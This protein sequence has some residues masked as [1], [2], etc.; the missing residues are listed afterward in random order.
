[1]MEQ[2]IKYLYIHKMEKYELLRA[3]LGQETKSDENGNYEINITIGIH[4]TDGFT[5][6]FSKDIIVTSNND[7]KGTEV[8]LQRDQEIAN[9]MAN[10]NK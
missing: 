3:D 2:H 4:P 9:F 10:I 1:M 8:D 6:D 5:P 7:M